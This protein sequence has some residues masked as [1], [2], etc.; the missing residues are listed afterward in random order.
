MWYARRETILLIR[1]K[2]RTVIFLRFER[3]NEFS[4]NFMSV[5]VD[6]TM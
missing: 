3:I 5:T 4:F 1:S 2:T 6:A